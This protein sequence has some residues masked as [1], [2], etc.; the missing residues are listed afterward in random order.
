MMDLVLHQSVVTENS[1]FRAM[2]DNACYGFETGCCNTLFTMGM[3]SCDY[4]NLSVSEDVVAIWSRF[5]L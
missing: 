1:I 3:M 2:D 4:F 5:T